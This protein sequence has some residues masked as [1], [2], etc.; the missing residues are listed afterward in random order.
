[1][2]LVAT[3]AS[4][5]DE[6]GRD[7]W[8]EAWARALGPMTVT[9]RAEGPFVCRVSTAR[10][11]WLRVCTIEAGPLRAGR[12]SR[13]IAHGA[14]GYVA[15]GVQ[16]AGR[17][18]LLQ[19]GRRADVGPGDLMVYDTTRPYSLDHPEPFT[20][21]V[22]LLPRRAVGVPREHLREVTGTA[23]TGSEGPGALLLSFLTALTASV[24]ACAP[25][26]GA[27]LATSVVDL[28][29]TLVDERT[30]RAEQPA[31]PREHLVQRVREH[32]DR[33]LRE[34]ALSPHTV[35]AAHHISVRY[36]HRLFEAEGIT[37][38]R[39]IQ[40][41]R[42]EEC[43]RELGRGGPPALTVSAVAYRWGFANAAHFSRVFR[44][45]YGV[46]PREWRGAGVGAPAG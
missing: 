14:E 25:A 23:I 39:L 18:T 2:N 11:G 4:V 15:L 5:P 22:V 42:L 35:A 32:I 3:T 8:R 20:T 38:G 21:R 17:A 13:H 33:H 7:D 37:V 9:P 10:L 36:L 41:R 29:A 16:T 28:F 24:P 12:T 34:P 19:D 46:S 45:V 6:E 44:T 1:M 31:D 43:A 26:V 30:G 27:R 40:R